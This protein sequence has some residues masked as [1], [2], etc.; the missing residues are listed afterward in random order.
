MKSVEATSMVNDLIELKNRSQTL[1]VCLVV[2][3]SLAATRLTMKA[4]GPASALGLS[5]VPAVSISP[6]FEQYQAFRSKRADD[7]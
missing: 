7:L 3:Q 4:L 5:D 1:R 2:L 6:I